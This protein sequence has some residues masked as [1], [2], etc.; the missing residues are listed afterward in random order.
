VHNPVFA[1]DQQSGDGTVPHVRLGRSSHM[2][3]GMCKDVFRTSS[4]ASIRYPGHRPTA[5]PRCA[6]RT[7]ERR[8]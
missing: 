4:A 7:P 1:H 8:T 3:Y 5:V 6:C 2:W